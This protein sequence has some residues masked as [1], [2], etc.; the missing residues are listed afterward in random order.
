M[1]QGNPF[2]AVQAGCHAVTVTVPAPTALTIPREL[3]PADGR[4]GCGPSKVRPEQLEALLAA[5]ST[6]HRDVPPPGAGQAG[7]RRRAR[8]ADRA[9]RPARRLGD[10]ARQRR[11]DRVLGRRLV[12]A[13]RA[14][15]PAPRVRRVLVEV[16]R[17][18][19]RGAR[20]SA[21]RSSSSSEPGDPPERRGA[22]RH[23]RL[24]AHPQRDLDRRGDGAAP[25][26][27]H[28]RRARRRRRHVGRRW[29]A[30][31]PGRGRRLLL[32]AAEVLRRRRRAV[33]RRLLAG[34]RRA[35]RAARRVGPLAPGVARPRHRPRP[36]AAS[37][38]RTTRRPSPR[39]CCSSRRCAGCSSPAASTG[40]SSAAR[41]RRATSTTGPSRATW[42]TPFVADPAKRSAVVGTIDL[43]AVDRGDEG[44]R[45]AAGQRHRRH[46]QLPQARPQPAAHRHVP[47]D[48]AG[49]R[50]G[51]DGV[52]RPPRRPNTVRS[53][54]R[55]DRR[56]G[57]DAR[58]RRAG[59]ADQPGA[60][61]RADRL[62]RR[63]RRGDGRPR[64]PRRRHGVTVGEIDADPFYDFTQE[65]PM[66]EMVDGESRSISW[67]ANEFTVVRT[68]GA[69]DLVVLNGVEPHLAWPLYI[70]LR[71]PGRRAARLRGRRDASGATADA[72]PHSRMPPVVGST[73]DPELARRLALSAPTYQGIT[74]LIGVLHVAMER[75]GVPTISLRV[76]VPHYL[77]HMEHPLA[78]GRARPAP[79][80]RARAAAD[81][82]RPGGRRPLGRPARRG[83]QRRRP[84]A[85][86]RPHAG[87]RVRPARRGDVAAGRRHRRPVRGLPPRA[88]R[89]PALRR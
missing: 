38:R 32:R 85:G 83:G 58:R 21:T 71:P 44:Q 64:P 74:G 62:V 75:A 48:R 2:G 76:G 10:R 30:V 68:G 46:R 70:A 13:R 43:D 81:D 65:R 59:A 86:L 69:H 45:R 36:T 39:C 53:L 77:G 18:L 52:H 16:R 33:A 40:A 63:R 25:A 78:V 3:L 42:A 9:V 50:R 19:R 57:P 60:A 34:R 56:R 4:F 8:R 17:G 88:A 41:R 15:Q 29:P 89:R 54:A 66:V 82:R 7:R 55:R 47:G 12:R 51:A 24:R 26:G 20:T 87:D 31:G 79:R 37:T 61:R 35:H 27:R 11:H 80:P 23:R 28:R 5:G 67:P 73:A 1:T 72:V 84:A 22:G 6:R 49:R 14:A